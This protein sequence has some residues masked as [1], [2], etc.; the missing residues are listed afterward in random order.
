MK[1]VDITLSARGVAYLLLC[2]VLLLAAVTIPM[3]LAE[4]HIRPFSWTAADVFR[5][6]T[7]NSENSVPAWFSAMLHLCSA[8]LLAICA[9]MH[10][11]RGN[12]WWKHWA[13]LSAIFCLLSL[14]EAASFHEILMVP[15]DRLVKAEGVFYFTWVIPGIAIVIA[16]GLAYLRFLWNLDSTTRYRFIAAACLFVG[17]AL[18][19]EMVDGAI[20][21][22]FGEQHIAYMLAT[23]VEETG[24]ML[25]LVVFIWSLISHLTTE[26]GEIRLKLA[27]APA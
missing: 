27:A 13:S 18:G 23:T 19:M 9:W 8:A 6:F 12:R 1:R 7:L 5:R 3:E 4:E 10:R 25:G 16:L 17:G 21:D 14:D 2:P 26:A 22:H 11:S 15:M 20:L 24:E